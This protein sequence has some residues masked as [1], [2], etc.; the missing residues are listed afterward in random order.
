MDEVISHRYKNRYDSA[1]KTQRTC[2]SIYWKD[3]NILHL[4][5]QRAEAKPPQAQLGECTHNA[6]QD[7]K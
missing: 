2:T 4:Q 5:M 7:R 3:T 1:S 6:K